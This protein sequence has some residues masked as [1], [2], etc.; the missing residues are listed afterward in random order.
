[1]CVVPM[2]VPENY[3]TLEGL[4]PNQ[5]ADASYSRA[6]VN[7][8]AGR[9]PV[10]SESKARGV[11]AI[12]HEI[13]ARGRGRPPGPEDVDPHRAILAGTATQLR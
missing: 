10:V 2:K 13:G 4:P 12:P 7:D 8:K 5:G 9:F 3:R 1:M 11:T 6:G